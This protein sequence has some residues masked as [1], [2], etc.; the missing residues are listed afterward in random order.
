MVMQP[1]DVAV[2][3]RPSGRFS[4]GATAA[5]VLLV[6]VGCA[7]DD[8]DDPVAESVTAMS[9]GSQ[10]IADVSP[11]SADAVGE[12]VFVTASQPNDAFWNVVK[13]GAEDAGSDLG[14]DVEYIGSETFDLT[15]MVQN[16]EA[17]IASS[18]AGIVVPI[19]DIS[20]LQAPIQ[21]AIDAGIPVIEIGS[22]HQPKGTLATVGSDDYEAG[23]VAGIRLADTGASNILC[24]NH[25]P[26]NTGLEERCRGIADGAESAT[27]TQIGVASVDPAA[28][29]QSIAAALH[30]N[31]D[32][33]AVV[34]SGAAEAMLALQTI[35]DDGFA[36]QV[37]LATFDLS[38]EVLE[39]INAGQ[40]LFALDQQQ[41]LMGYLPVTY[42]Y[43]YVRYLVSPV[44]RVFTGPGV[45][46][47]E[48]AARIIELSAIGVR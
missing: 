32:L 4:A 41:Y 23:K 45:V 48:T 2:R 34:T 25:E 11:G 19:Y 36:E 37:A 26:G 28:F 8:N 27:V 46:T 38:P 6:S 15:R 12:I 1:T 16:M 35:T 47:Q 7:G 10:P 9:S 43:N 17:A 42:I 20:V 14:V 5:I 40:I 22:A 39:A 24:V 30:Q 31:A 29:Q 13:R 18:P 33:D 3:S 21:K 44:G